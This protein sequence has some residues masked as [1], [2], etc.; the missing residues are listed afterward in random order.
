M[1]LWQAMAKRVGT[2]RQEKYMGK[3][4]LRNRDGLE[5]G[6]VGERREGGLSTSIFSLFLSQERGGPQI[7]VERKG[8]KGEGRISERGEGESILQ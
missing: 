7:I 6:R 3:S 4:G 1:V 2:G 5:E 8:P